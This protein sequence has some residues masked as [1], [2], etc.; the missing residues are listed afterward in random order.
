MTSHHRIVLTG[1]IVASLSAT[2]PTLATAGPLLSGYGGPGEGSQAI[3]GS[4]LLGAGSGGGGS[5]GSAGGPSGSSSGSFR[6]GERPGETGS[7]TTGAAGTGGTGARKS[8]ARG[9][10]SSRAGR[11]SGGGA[12]TYPASSAEHTSLAASVGSETL[13]LSGGDLLYIVLMLAALAFTGVLTRRLARTKGVGG[14]QQLKGRVAK[15]E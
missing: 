3:L 15:P 6:Y 5:G 14:N 10:S 7:S 12:S 2:T 1:L 8:A 11:A 4:T 9:A 13:G